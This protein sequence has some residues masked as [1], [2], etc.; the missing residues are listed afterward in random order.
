MVSSPYDFKASLQF[1]PHG[2]AAFNQFDT[3]PGFDSLLVYKDYCF[4]WYEV[5]S[6]LGLAWLPK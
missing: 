5:H 4:K 3:S 2:I 1:L 6:E